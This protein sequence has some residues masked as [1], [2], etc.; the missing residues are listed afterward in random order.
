MN[1]KNKVYRLAKE[2]LEYTEKGDYIFGR[3]K[4]GWIS[5]LVDLLV[6]IATELGLEREI[7]R[8]LEYRINEESEK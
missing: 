3:E 5:D 8:I 6:V 1:K 4:E 7:L 2:L